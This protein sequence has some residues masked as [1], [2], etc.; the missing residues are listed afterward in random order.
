MNGSLGKLDS[1]TCCLIL[2]N[3]AA[4]DIKLTDTVTGSEVKKVKVELSLKTSYHITN[5]YKI[6]R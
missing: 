3:I 2:E 4:A 6:R 5:V 1:R